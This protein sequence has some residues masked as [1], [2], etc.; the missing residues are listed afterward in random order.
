MELVDT[1]DLKSLGACPRDGSS[2]SSGTRPSVSSINGVSSP[3]RFQSTCLH[4]LFRTNSRLAL[5]R[6]QKGIHRGA[7]AERQ[8]GEMFCIDY[9]IMLFIFST[10]VSKSLSKGTWIFVEQE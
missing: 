4:F 10:I 1:R 3:C 5:I 8:F 9:W 2:P 7:R 6:I